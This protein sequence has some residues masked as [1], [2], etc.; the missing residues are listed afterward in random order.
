MILVMAPNGKRSAPCGDRD[1]TSAHATFALAFP[2]SPAYTSRTTVCQAPVPVIH[3]ESHAFIAMHR[4]S[5][6][7]RPYEALVV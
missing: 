4:E 6:P 1:G 7:A 2:D 5:H 3:N